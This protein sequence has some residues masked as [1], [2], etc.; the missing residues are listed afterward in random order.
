MNH[1]Y[2]S[3]YAHDKKIYNQ[4]WFY[5]VSCNYFNNIFLHEFLHLVTKLLKLIIENKYANT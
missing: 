3:K 4:C 5:N 1:F 2:L